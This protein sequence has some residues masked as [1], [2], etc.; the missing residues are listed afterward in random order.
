MI[1]NSKPA[2]FKFSYCDF[3]LYC[4]FLRGNKSH[5]KKITK[6][7]S[8]IKQ[9]KTSRRSNHLVR[10]QSAYSSEDCYGN[11]YNKKK[12]CEAVIEDCEIIKKPKKEIRKEHV[13]HLSAYFSKLIDVEFA[14]QSNTKKVF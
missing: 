5:K 13:E 6:T 8:W 12:G 1:S 9:L 11:T 10:S 4:I 3:T 14:G 2:W 7:L